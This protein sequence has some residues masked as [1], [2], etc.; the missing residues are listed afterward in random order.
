[1]VVVSA[2]DHALFDMVVITVVPADAHMIM[3]AVALDFDVFVPVVVPRR[4]VLI[5]LGGHGSRG[6]ADTCQG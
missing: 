5:V 1:M 2:L 4:A 6:E 3:I